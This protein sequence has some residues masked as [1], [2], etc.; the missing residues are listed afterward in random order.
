[1]GLVNRLS[2][3]L[4]SAILPEQ[5]AQASGCIQCAGAHYMFCWAEIDRNGVRTKCSSCGSC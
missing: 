2:D 5:K 4:L 1:M 3:A